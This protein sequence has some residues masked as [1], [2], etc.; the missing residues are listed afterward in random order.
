MKKIKAKR[1][2][3]TQLKINPKRLYQHY[4]G[5]YM[6]RHTLEPISIC[7]FKKWANPSL[8]FVYFWSYQTNINTI[9]TTNQ[10]EKISIQYTALGFECMTS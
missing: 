2:G 4:I 6:I 10:C 1:P 3:I 9:L 7:F 8:F 5:Y